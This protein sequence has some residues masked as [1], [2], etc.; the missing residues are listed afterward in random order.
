MKTKTAIR[1][2][3]FPPTGKRSG[4]EDSVLL[5]SGFLKSI[6]SSYCLANK[7]PKRLW[8]SSFFFFFKWGA[9]KNAV[10]RPYLFYTLSSKEKLTNILY[11]RRIS[12][13]WTRAGLHCSTP[14]KTQ[15]AFVTVLCFLLTQLQNIDFWVEVPGDA[16]IFVF[17]YIFDATL[18]LIHIFLYN[19][20][21]LEIFF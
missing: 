9:Y 10:S 21:S 17:L 12:S 11:L 16:S 19:L 20:P 13:W 7:C 5:L 4:V 8:G 1:S 14:T 6:G 2:S 15:S 18:N 3:D